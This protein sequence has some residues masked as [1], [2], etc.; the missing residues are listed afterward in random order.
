MSN[1]ADGYLGDW[2]PHKDKC[3]CD[4]CSLGREVEALKLENAQW[5]TWG[6]IEIAVRNPNVAE[7]M[8]HWERRATEAE[9][10][11]ESL[12]SEVRKLMKYL[13]HIQWETF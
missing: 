1:A 2:L 10:K 8:N 12:A 6:I 9:A 13:S 3:R 7:Y 11:I 5:R 4:E